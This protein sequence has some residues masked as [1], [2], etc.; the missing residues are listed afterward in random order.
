MI[1]NKLYI[2][3]LAGGMG[4]RMQSDLPK[5]LH[6]VKGEVMIVRLLNQVVQLNPDKIL[7][8]V[9][10]FHEI[11]RNEINKFINDDRII[12]INQEQPLGTGDA[13]KCTLSEFNEPNI[14]NIILNGDV[15]MLQYQ[16]IKEIYDYY[17]TQQSNF[18]ITSINLT[19]PTGNGRIIL[20]VDNNFKEIV[21]EKDCSDEQKLITLA[22]C[23]IY[24]LC[25]DVLTKFIPL[26]KN[27][28]AQAEY[29]L[30]D[31]VKIYKEIMNK[32][33]DL[34]ILDSEKEIEIYNVNTKEQ[35]LYIEQLK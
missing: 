5:V 2:T 14:I 21:E 7:I 6:Q 18:L 17:L 19:N 20:D 23:G 31:L 15:P 24:I 35:L 30:T 22:N 26:I 32:K 13:V 10:K 16:T 28:N 9:G 29:Y 12:Y 11:I 4:K 3:L 25:S 33:I 27:N 8:V 34:L 1:T